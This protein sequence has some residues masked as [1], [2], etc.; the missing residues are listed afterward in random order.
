MI[1]GEMRLFRNPNM[2]ILTAHFGRILDIDGLDNVSENLHHGFPK[3]MSRTFMSETLKKA[4]KVDPRPL[5][6]VFSW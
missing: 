6:G 2:I 3:E 1:L 5:A 4:R